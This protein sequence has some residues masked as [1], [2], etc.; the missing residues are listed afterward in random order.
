MVRALSDAFHQTLDRVAVL[1]SAE[2][3]HCLS[4]KAPT[5]YH[6]RG[7]KL[8]QAILETMR[9][10]RILPDVLDPELLTIAASCG[11]RP[12]KILEGI[13]EEIPFSVRVLH[14]EAQVGI[15]FLTASISFT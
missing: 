9:H 7:K 6:E 10:G 11:I 1:C 8:D 12:L 14:Y 13:L 3:A 2:L 5:P 15:G 4:S